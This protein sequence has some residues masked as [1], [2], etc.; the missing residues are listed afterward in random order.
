MKLYFLIASIFVS[1]TAV[2]Q[3][4][5]ED[6]ADSA[7]TEVEA[8]VP[9]T[10]PIE[11]IEVIS[12][13]SFHSLRLNIGFA[14]EKLFSTFNELNTDDDFD[15]RCRKTR[16]GSS[17]IRKH[18]C[19]PA[20]FDDAIAEHAQDYAQGRYIFLTPN[21][22]RVHEQGNFEKLE[23]TMLKLAEEHESLRKDLL[24]LSVLEQEFKVRQEACM[25]KPAVLLLFRRC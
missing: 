8:V 5:I 9:N 24:E 16:L 23:A 20:F 17:R 18:D 21:E 1:M 14:E 19:Y 25:K 22:I 12:R 7:Q 10:R 11:E 13:R 3:D 4:Q 6:A 15:I 2:A